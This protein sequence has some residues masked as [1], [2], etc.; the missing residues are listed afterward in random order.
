MEENGGDVD[1]R[2]FLARC[3][4]AT[5]WASVATGPRLPIG[6]R[7]GLPMLDWACS[8][9]DLR[10]AQQL[11]LSYPNL[12]GADLFQTPR[13]IGPYHEITNPSDFGDSSPQRR[14]IGFGAIP[15]VEIEARKE[16]AREELKRVRRE[17]AKA[18]RARKSEEVRSDVT[19]VLLTWQQQG[20]DVPETLCGRCPKAVWMVSDNGVQCFCRFIRRH[21]YD[22]MDQGLRTKINI[23]NG[24]DEAVL[25]SP[26]TEPGE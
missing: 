18:Q 20:G 26:V 6:L 5:S 24:Y 1:H 16:R 22:S 13:P 21:T 4:E 12:P 17:Q 19:P 23:C 11:A 9:L 2:D 14:P 25:G 8:M 3:E 15:A 7:D 10:T